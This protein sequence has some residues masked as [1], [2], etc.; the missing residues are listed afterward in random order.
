[1]IYKKEL[2]KYHPEWTR[3]TIKWTIN[4]WVIYAEWYDSG[5]GWVR[6]FSHGWG[7]RWK[8][9][10]EPLIFSERQGLTKSWVVGSY[11]FKILKPYKPI[12]IT[13]TELE[14]KEKA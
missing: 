3:D 7:I 4:L 8:P 13:H 12:K 9:K 11:R 2:L 14:L 10:S 5:F 1:M 6:L